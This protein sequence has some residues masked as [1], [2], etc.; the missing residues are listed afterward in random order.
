MLWLSRL[1]A[2]AP[3]LLLGHPHDD[4]ALRPAV[5]LCSGL[6]AS[7][8][9]IR[10]GRVSRGVWGRRRRRRRRCWCFRAAAGQ[11][12]VS[13]AVDV[14]AGGSASCDLVAA[15]RRLLIG[16]AA[17]AFVGTIGS[18]GR[19][20]RAARAIEGRPPA[21]Q[22]GEYS[23]AAQKVTD[24]GKRRIGKLFQEALSAPTV[25]EEEAVWT[26]IL[27]AYSNIPEIAAR[28]NCNRGNSRVRQGKFKE[29]LADYDRA[30]AIAPF[31]V[32]GYLNRGASYEMLGRFD[33]ALTDYNNALS[34][35]I[36]D[37]AAWNNRGNVLLG[38]G[39]WAEARDALKT[40]LSYSG[41]QT[42]AIAAV[43]LNLAEYEL[44]NDE[45]VLKDLRSLLARYA[46]TFP[47]ARAFYALMLWE[48]GDVIEA[49]AQWDRATANDVRYKDVTWVTTI[50]R[51]TPRLV[52]VLQ[53]FAAT[54]KVKVK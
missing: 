38:M 6:G 30:I 14:I 31:E 34:I 3:P 15:C 9:E 17:V 33:E 49:E 53:R 2:N 23:A 32:D 40:A 52:G 4:A 50:R 41:P 39:R 24:E 25:E 7:D 16:V 5:L 21:G 43:N 51:W 13:A 12:R 37:A 22:R 46:D 54:T 19:Q 20:Q 26:R 47:D 28:V 45:A 10:P 48:R 1:S 35:N 18:G 8:A 11:P 42:L 29:G 36:K 27:D 44:G